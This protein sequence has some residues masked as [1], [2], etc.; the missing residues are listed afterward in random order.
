VRE[1]TVEEYDT[2]EGWLA[3]YETEVKKMEAGR[4]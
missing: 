3:R 1:L 4:G 2:L